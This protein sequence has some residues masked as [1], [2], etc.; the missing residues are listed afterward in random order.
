[1]YG[2]AAPQE[3]FPLARYSRYC[4]KVF[5]LDQ[6][7][8]SRFIA[9]LVRLLK[10]HPIDV[11]VP[12]GHPLVHYV[13]KHASELRQHTRF[14][15]P[16]LEAE[17]L[18]TDKLAIMGFAERLGLPVPRTVALQSLDDVEEAATKVGIPLIIK[19]RREGS[20]TLLARV[21]RLELVRP[22]V[23]D[24]VERFGLHAPEDYPILQEYVPGWG[25]GFFA[26]YE[27]G[28]CKR[29]FI[30]AAFAN[31]RR[32]EGSVAVPFPSRQPPGR[33]GTKA[34]RR[35]ALARGR[36]DGVSFRRNQK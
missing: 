10:D 3:S 17:E 2:A 33:A 9:G 11:L 20:R 5:R 32:P 36:N 34:A 24:L 30:T 14:A 23:A 31:T 12:V 19:G 18:A 16:P 6:D 26:T 13:A 8:E 1:M 22:T 35:T 25:C 21:D 29:V 28:A 7:D 27:H 15:V 4:T